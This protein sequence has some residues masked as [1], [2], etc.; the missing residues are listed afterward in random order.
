VKA[1]LKTFGALFALYAP[2]QNSIKVSPNTIK[3][4]QQKKTISFQ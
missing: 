4:G 3:G 1:Q 2:V